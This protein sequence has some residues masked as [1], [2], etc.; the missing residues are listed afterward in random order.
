MRYPETIRTDVVR[1]VLDAYAEHNALDLSDISLPPVRQ[2]SDLTTRLITLSARVQLP[3]HF[4][5]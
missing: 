2:V 4:G 1:A 5:A 3:Q